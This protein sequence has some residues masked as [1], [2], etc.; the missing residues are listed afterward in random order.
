VVERCVAIGW[1][2]CGECSC[3][4]NC[5]TPECNEINCCCC[6]IVTTDASHAAA[7]PVEPPYGTGEY[8]GS[9]VYR[10]ATMNPRYPLTA[11]PSYLH[12]D[13]LTPAAARPAAAAAAAAGS[14]ASGGADAAR[15]RPASQHHQPAV[16]AAAAVFTVP[17]AGATSPPPP[18]D[19]T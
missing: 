14:L 11:R 12:A 6:Q 1:L 16:A 8:G 9:V 4:C 15:R 18:C 13:T 10:D 7:G 3:S 19:H 5:Q 2:Q 17:A